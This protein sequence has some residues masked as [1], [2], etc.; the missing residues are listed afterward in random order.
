MGS[1][2]NHE[3]KYLATI[4]LIFLSHL[5]IALFWTVIQPIFGG[6]DETAHVV[7][8]VAIAS[9]QF[10]GAPAIGDFGFA[11]EIYEVPK[12]Y[13]AQMS[14][15]S[16][17]VGNVA[18]PATCQGSLGNDG[19]LT[20][21]SSTASH[22]PP[23]YYAIVGLPG[24]LLPGDIG[25]YM[26]RALSALLSA[27]VLTLASYVALRRRS[28]TVAMGG[29]FAASPMV[30][31]L[32]GSVNPHAFEIALAILWWTC[33]VLSV[34]EQIS[35]HKQSLPSLYAIFVLA[36]VAA[37][38]TRPAEFIF[39]SASNTLL[40][41]A[42]IVTTVQDRDMRFQLRNS[43][44]AFVRAMGIRLWFLIPGV[45]FSIV[46]WQLTYEPLLAGGEP[47]TPSLIDNFW[48]S[49][50]R[51][52]FYFNAMFGWFG[53]V[54]FLIPP[55]SF[56]ALIALYATLM[57]MGDGPR[58]SSGLRVAALAVALATPMIPVVLESYNASNGGGFGYQGRYTL[59]IFCGL[60]L[61]SL[62]AVQRVSK[63]SALVITTFYITGTF[64]AH[65]FAWKRW[66]HG[67]D[68]KYWLSEISW[69]LSE[70][71]FY[72]AMLL[73]TH[74]CLLVAS[75][76]RLRHQSALTNTSLQNA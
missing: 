57:G 22:Y 14:M 15:I 48:I 12:A 67:T 47:G 45:L 49:Y 3:P 56:F 10:D 72:G 11:A 64:G 23:L 50:E 62:G 9:G 39:I 44:S 52:D 43:P 65:L 70:G 19:D 63:S 42:I 6:P 38:L 1:R 28:A 54:E 30:Y 76:A 75:I 29:I 46:F 17:Y 37:T 36:Q 8:A 66:S 53:W 51:S 60:A 71:N 13:E 32:A 34:K 31:S 25:F 73:S 21:L 20:Q 7:K 27:T 4:Y 18:V 55:F 35:D 16:C 24:R 58:P 26:M 2:N 41:V 59:S 40:M 69:S 68:G 5:T 33:G 74:L 61:L